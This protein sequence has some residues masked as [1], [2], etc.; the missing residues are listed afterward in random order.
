MWHR[1]A[2]K[3]AALLN[4]LLIRSHQE[5]GL[6]WFIS[7]FLIQAKATVWTDPNTSIFRW[8]PEDYLKLCRVNNSDAS[9]TF[10]HGSVLQLK[11][12]D[13]MDALRG[14]KPKGVAVDE[15]GEIAR[16]YGSELREAVLEP[17]IRSSGGWIDYAGTPKG[18]NDFSYLLSLGNTNS[19]YWGSRRTVEDTGLYSEREIEDM[20][21]NATNLDFFRQEYYCEILE[22]ANSVFRS[23]ELAID[24]QLE[25]PR[26][27]QE[28]VFGIDLGRTFDSTII[29]GFRGSQLVYFERLTNVPWQRQKYRIAEILGRYNDAT[30]VIDAT[31]IGDSFVD[32]LYRMGLHLVQYKITNNLIKRQLVERLAAYIENRTITFPNIPELIDELH[33][34]EYEISSRNNVTYSA[35]SGKHDDIVM[36][37]AL[38]CTKVELNLEAHMPVDYYPYNDSIILDPKTGYPR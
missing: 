1:G 25:D 36:A 12:A 15:Y 32:E 28:Y 7:P 8:I 33:S 34:F 24:G 20:R 27:R 9:I 19:E 6:Y 30:A 5:L 2:R 10:P 26:P 38:A 21:G 29:V 22:G 16:R 35:P 18:S 31:G 17:S 37:L 14:P 3:T 23:V 4:K 13:H 11:G